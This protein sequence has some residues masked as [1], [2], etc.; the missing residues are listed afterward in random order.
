MN[1]EDLSRVKKKEVFRTLPLNFE[2]SKNNKEYE[3]CNNF[4]FG[5]ILQELCRRL[6]PRFLN[7][8]QLGISKATLQCLN[9]GNSMHLLR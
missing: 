1:S 8:S 7:N 4:L 6:D 9:T 5:Q 3:Y 2:V